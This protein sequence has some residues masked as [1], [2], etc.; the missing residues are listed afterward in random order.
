MDKEYNEEDEEEVLPEPDVD[1]LGYISKE[2]SSIT[3]AS[4]KIS[5]LIEFLSN[6][7]WKFFKQLGDVVIQE[8]SLKRYENLSLIF[9]IY[10]SIFAI[11]DQTIIEM[12][13][14]D[15]FYKIT[16][17]ALECRHYFYIKS[18]QMQL[19]LKTLSSIGSSLKIL[20]SRIYFSLMIK[21]LW[22]R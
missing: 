7:N 18:I 22:R 5:K 17:T 10:K 3:L 13:V 11:A 16:F 19:A 12:L 6:D 2:I 15:Q 14:S 21:L 8:E 1:N 4:S 20:I 9:T